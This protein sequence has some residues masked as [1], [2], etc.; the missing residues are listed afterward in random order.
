METHVHCFC[1][2]RLDV[3]IDDTKCCVDVI[4]YLHW[5]LLV[6]HFFKCMLLGDGLV[7]VDIQHTKFGFGGR[8]HDSIDELGN[9]EECTIVFGV[10]GV[11]GQEKVS[12]GATACFGFA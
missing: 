10:G 9:V 5:G 7:G 6:S 2:L 11:G 12:A 8:G 1:S 3:I 4:L